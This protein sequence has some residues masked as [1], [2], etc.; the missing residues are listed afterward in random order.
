MGPEDYMFRGRSKLKAT[1]KPAMIPN[2]LHD[3]QY[4]ISYIHIFQ[5]TSFDNIGTDIP[6]QLFLGL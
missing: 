4:E 2:G 5:E 3:R 6:F 1:S